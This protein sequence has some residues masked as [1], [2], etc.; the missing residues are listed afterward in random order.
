MHRTALSII[1]QK[2]DK[3]ALRN[4]EWGKRHYAFWQNNTIRNDTGKPG[5]SVVRMVEAWAAYA[6][7]HFARF[8]SLIGDDY[9]LGVAWIEQGKA[10]RTL[11][12]GECGPLDCGAVDSML[13]DIMS[14]NGVDTAE[15]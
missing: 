5:A 3:A 13:L 2:N 7:E 12:N 11:L 6:D 1:D 9:V 14:A 10:L 8:E 4:A 15:F